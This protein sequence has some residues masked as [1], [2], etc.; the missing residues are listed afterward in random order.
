MVKRGF[1]KLFFLLLFPLLTQAQSLSDLPSHLPR[2]SHDYEEVLQRTW[3]G[4]KKRNID[5][6]TTGMVHRPKSEFPGDAVSEGVGYGMILA[7]Y[8]DDQAYFNKVWN[9]GERFM[10]DGRLYNW[11]RDS[12]GK[13]NDAMGPHND[14]AASDAEEDIAIML[15]FADQLVEHGI[16]EPFTSDSGATY[17]ERAR[18]ILRTIRETMIADGRYLRPGNFWGGEDFVNP[19][20]FAPAFYRVFAEFEPEH[21]NTWMSLIDGSYDVIERN[22]GYALGLVPDWCR[23]DGDTI[24]LPPPGEGSILGYN[25]Y[26]GGQ[27]FYKDAVRI[28]WRLATDYLWYGEP[29][30][31]A[32]LDNAY[33]FVDTPEKA[34]FFQID[35]SLLPEEDT[36]I[37]AN[38]DTLQRPRREHSHLTLGMW[39]T[40]AMG[41]G[42]PEAAEPFSERLLEEFYTP[43]ED[44][45]GKASCPNGEDTLHNEMYFDQ[46][47]A[48]FGA[49]LIS[50]KFI[51]VWEVLQDPD[52]TTPLEWVDR[53]TLSGRSFDANEGAFTIQGLFN[54]P[55]RWTVELKHRENENSSI[56]F[57][58]NS[59]T[60]S[61]NW[62]GLSNDGSVI[63][64]GD[65]D[66]TISARGLSETI[67]DRVW[68]SRALDLRD[69]ERLIVDDFAARD[70]VPY[71]GREW[72][73]YTDSYA[74]GA[75][76][77]PEF[78]VVEHEGDSWVRWAYTLD[79]GG[80]HFY[81]YAALEWNC[82]TADGNLDLT[83]LDTIIVVARSPQPIGVSV[84]LIT[85]GIDNHNFY[86]DSL[87]LTPESQKFKLPVSQFTPR[88]G[89]DRPL[90]LDSLT[91]I[92]FQVQKPD[93]S[94][95][96]IWIESMHFAGDLDHLYSPPPEYLPLSA[97]RTVAFT[98]GHKNSAR[99]INDRVAFSFSGE[100]GGKTVSIFD[101]SGRVVD[102]LTLSRD[103]MVKWD[104]RR[105]NAGSGMY[106]AVVQ[107]GGK[108]V[109]LPFRVMR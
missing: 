52:P 40:A 92:R 26:L 88:Q 22:P 87:Y 103:G 73:S 105:R 44:F 101:V 42:G 29:R 28:H 17:G 39:A 47:L 31:K 16:W 50:G 78:E 8:S 59:D 5:P 69:G 11:R 49:S 3:E 9:G 32:F 90:S 58:G 83:G 74:G 55:A 86:E 6:W 68:L 20:Y 62:Y 36:F 57:S 72:T 54:K 12:E 56:S 64:Y 10:W 34:N 51:N 41:S 97:R 37:L 96:E 67:T 63:E 89:G 93:G 48:W 7:L 75:S 53:P 104:F 13:N 43:G 100:L 99:L 106:F 81:P 65:Y 98:S 19:A 24:P 79:Q 38:N 94:E 76:V 91:A 71:F 15:I 66:V 84:Q 77:V 95:G 25:A 23:P 80:L 27:G 21:R 82:T 70:L 1:S 33:A 107:Q 30:A 109:T 18:D 35:G 2:V 108:R 4:I 60:L 14:G 46:F 85:L 102:R 61:V 45:W